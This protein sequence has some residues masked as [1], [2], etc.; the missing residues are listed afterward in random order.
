MIT[1]FITFKNVGWILTYS[2]EFFSVN[3]SA[4][5]TIKYWPTLMLPLFIENTA[6]HA[7]IVNIWK[8]KAL[9]LLWYFHLSLAKRLVGINVGPAA[10]KLKIT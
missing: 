5:Q 10:V 4:Y 2:E 9:N 7:M 1:G 3:V 6:D 8:F